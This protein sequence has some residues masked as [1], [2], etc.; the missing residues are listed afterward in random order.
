MT[1]Q[2]DSESTMRFQIFRA[3][4]GVDFTDDSVMYPEPM[5]DVNMKGW[6]KLS[7]AGYNDGH[8]TKLLFSA[9]GF[10]LTHAWFKSGLPLPRHSHNVDCLY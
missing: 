6:P 9:P 5:S 2:A 7:E 4:D 8:E 3:R 1:E 10:S